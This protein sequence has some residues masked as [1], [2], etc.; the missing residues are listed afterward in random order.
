MCLSLSLCVCLSSVFK[1]TYY[2][3]IFMFTYNF[4]FSF[5]QVWSPIL[6]YKQFFFYFLFLNW[7][8]H[9]R[10]FHGC[11]ACVDFAPF[12]S[13]SSCSSWH[14]H[15]LSSS[16]SKP[17]SHV[18]VS[19]VLM[20]HDSYHMHSSHMYFITFLPFYLFSTWLFFKSSLSTL[21]AP[22]SLHNLESHPDSKRRIS[23]SVFF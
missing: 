7:V 4:M 9:S 19:H 11:P 13:L 1:K 18:F 8:H 17:M 10:E 6:Y 15:L 22:L 14:F 5:I 3:P 16:P 21:M 12:V 23:T 2:Y 20:A